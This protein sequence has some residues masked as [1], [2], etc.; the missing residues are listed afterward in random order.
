MDVR[1]F[2]PGDTE[3]VRLGAGRE[4]QRTPRMS[5][6]VGKLHLASSGANGNGPRAEDKCNLVRGVKFGRAE[7]QPVRRRSAGEIILLQ[8]RP[9]IGPLVFG[10]QHR[11]PPG[12]AFAPQHFGRGLPRRTAADDDNRFR[13]RG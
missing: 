12:I 13:R 10:A 5:G 4:Q 6:T 2:G 1:E 9:V 8:I 11:H 7:R 3:S